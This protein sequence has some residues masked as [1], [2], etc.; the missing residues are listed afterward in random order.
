MTVVAT[1]TRCLCPC[2]IR[3]DDTSYK[4]GVDKR[5]HL[6]CI[7]ACDSCRIH[8]EPALYHDDPPSR[9][10]PQPDTSTAWSDQSDG[11]GRE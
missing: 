2:H 6:A 4:Y 9:P 5:S 10:L 7:L 3:H 8:H 11:E 1:I